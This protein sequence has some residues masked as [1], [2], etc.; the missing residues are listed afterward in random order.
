MD[1]FIT[2][3]GL[4][5]CY[6][7]YGTGLPMVAIHGA[8][9]GSSLAVWEPCIEAVTRSGFQLIAFDQPGFGH[10]E[11]PA[12]LSLAY[13]QHI[14]EGFIRQLALGPVVV[15]GHS[16]GGAMAV[17]LALDH[18][19]LVRGV[20]VLGTGS[21]LPPN[22][23]PFPEPEGREGTDYE[24][25]REDV[26]T[27]L[28][29]QLYHQSYITDARLEARYAASVGE[30]FVAFQRR[31]ALASPRLHPALWTRL[32]EIAV[33][34]VMM[35]GANDRADTPARVQQAQT[36]FP[37]IPIQLLSGCGHLIPWDAPEPMANALEK[38]LR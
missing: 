20:G 5:I 31:N 7:V 12:D 34:L 32:P 38:W 10:S 28:K 4:R 27:L 25:R 15:V 23:P 6:H 2:V 1:S 36:R 21:L 19:D 26:R 30:N 22:T 13:R 17:G 35:Y 29:R 3:D 37:A 11:H 14:L 8:S 24:P 9:L 18:I 16:Q 33:P